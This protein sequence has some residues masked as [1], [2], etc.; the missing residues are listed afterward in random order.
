LSRWAAQHPAIPIN[1]DIAGDGPERAALEM[2]FCPANL[3]VRF[4]GN[5]AY[6]QLSGVYATAD[7]LVFPTFA[8]EWGVVVNEALASG[9][10]V[11]GSCHSQA[12]DELVVD[13]ETGWR[14]DPEIESTID[15]ALTALFATTESERERMGAAGRRLA[16][17]LT[18][19][20]VAERIANAVVCES[21]LSS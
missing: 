9:L 7:V 10:P 17:E 2:L 4:L 12:V 21:H 20:R 18:P 16:L 5:V 6:D 3:I 19:A 13:G 14:F 11:L 1:F 15:A 8:D